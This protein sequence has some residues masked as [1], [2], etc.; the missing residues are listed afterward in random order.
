MFM[1]ATIQSTVSGPPSH[2]GS[3]WMPMNGNV[4]RL[5]QTPNATG[6]AAAASWPA[7]FSNQRRPRKSSI[8]PT[9]TATAAPSRSP[10][11]SR[12]TLRNAS[13]GTKMPRKSASPPR[14][15]IGTRFSAPPAGRVHGAEHPRHPADRGGQGDDDRERDERPPDHLEVSAE[16]VE[17][18][19]VATAAVAHERG[20]KHDGRVLRC[21]KAVA[22]VTEA[23][24]PSA[25]RPT[26]AGRDYVKPRRVRGRA[27]RLRRLA[28]ERAESDSAQATRAQC[29]GPRAPARSGRPESG[30][31]VP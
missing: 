18:V 14:R 15:G 10:R 16:D 23:L 11:F 5:T 7:S 19:V 12:P 21:V 27:S 25:S 1:I 4:K 20:D 3:A 31:F 13:A 8:A 24:G 2:P 26:C 30:Y 22:C 17:D 6:I 28:S 9:V 29:A